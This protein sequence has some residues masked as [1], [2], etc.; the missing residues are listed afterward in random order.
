MN[1]P[2]NPSI[3]EMIDNGSSG[4]PFPRSWMPG[5][6]DTT[7]AVAWRHTQDLLHRLAH[8]YLQAPKQFDS[9]MRSLFAGENQSEQARLAGVTR[10]AISAGLLL[11][12]AGSTRPDVSVPRPIKDSRE[13]MIYLLYF[14][15]GCS[16][17]SVSQQT[18]IPSSTVGRLV[19]RLRSKLA[20]NGTSLKKK[21]KKKGG[22]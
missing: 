3:S 20:Q 13:R 8:M 6:D 5:M 14:V 19:Q 17:R 21:K 12:Y 4:T 9:C 2:F 11:E 15:D 10:Q 16:I 22:A 1:V 18:K 7:K